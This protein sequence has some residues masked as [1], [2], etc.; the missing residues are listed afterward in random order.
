MSGAKIGETAIDI[1]F[2]VIAFFFF[3][4]SNGLGVTGILTAALLHESGHLA[5]LKSMGGE[6]KEIKVN[7]KGIAIKT[8][9]KGIRTLGEE[10]FL[11]LS[12]PIVG[13]IGAIAAYLLHFKEFGDLNMALSLF[14]L[15]PIKGLDGGAALENVLEFNFGENGV[16]VSKIISICTI[17]L[18]SFGISILLFWLYK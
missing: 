12:G 6:I 7:L 5:A 14:N 18:V 4:A 9:G 10:L 3:A 17:A 8:I 16:R 13:F 11:N 15:L 2:W 1:S